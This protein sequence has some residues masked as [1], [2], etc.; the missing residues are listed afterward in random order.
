MSAVT[1]ASSSPSSPRTLP[2]VAAF[3]RRDFAFARSYNLPFIFDLFFGVL[4]LAIYFFLSRTFEQV[5]PAELDGAPSYFAFAAVGIVI[6]LV[7]ESAI[8]GVATKVREGQLTGSLEALMAQPVTSFQLCLGFTG[9][10][11]VFAVA[12]AA[13]YL[14]IAALV[15]GLEIDNADWA[16]LGVIFLTSAAAIAS[17]GILGG[18]AVMV[19]KRGDALVGLLVF[20]LT[21]ISGSLFPVSALP[22]WLADVGSFQPLRLAFD[23]ARDALFQGS[24]W[25]DE[26]L[27]LA[28][29]AVVSVPAAV[30][31]FAQA[32]DFARRAGSV[33]EY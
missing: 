18:A 23:G 19:F 31:L 7:I 8:Q 25:G 32:L 27:G 6:S 11:F 1:R 33:G 5:G 9:F 10:P 2:L 28:A 3:M 22:D 30:W 12:R 14:F 16:G 29:F 4:Q 20:G 15:M 21:L 17:L 13:F 24:G 26:A